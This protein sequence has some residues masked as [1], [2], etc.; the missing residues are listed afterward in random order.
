[1]RTTALPVNHQFIGPVHGP[2]RVPLPSWWLD[3]PRD[4]PIVYVNLGSSGHGRLLPGVLAVLRDLPVTV[5]AASAGRVE[6][7][8]L[9]SGTFVTDFLP[10]DQA[11][12]LASIVVC[13]GGSPTQVLPGA[14]CRQALVVGVPVNLDQYLNMSLVARFGA[15]VLIRGGS[16]TQRSLTDAVQ[17]ILATP[18][19]GV[20]ARAVQ[21][22]IQRY[23]PA[24]AFSLVLQKA[25]DP[26]WTRMN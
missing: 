14:G 5:I 11:A 12:S 2:P 18:S 22:C 1:M 6:L 7:G 8:G 16:Y 20:Q 24:D 13:N 3:V 21:T 26:K 4:K 9:G 23:A 15:G 10:G 19:F 17:K 25:L